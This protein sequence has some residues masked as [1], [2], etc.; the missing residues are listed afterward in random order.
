MLFAGE[1]VVFEW[2]LLNT[3]IKLF[4]QKLRKSLFFDYLFIIS[5]QI[6]DNFETLKQTNVNEVVVDKANIM[7]GLLLEN[8]TG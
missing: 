7:C 4:T 3:R 8:K 6:S 2:W 1:Y 5:F